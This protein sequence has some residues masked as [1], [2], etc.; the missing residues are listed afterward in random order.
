DQARARLEAALR[1]WARRDERVAA[2]ISSIEKKRSKHI[3]GVLRDIG[4][5]P[6]LAESW[7][8]IA[9][10]VYLGW[11]DRS[12]RDSEFQTTGRSLSESLSDLILAASDRSAPATR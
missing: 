7:A 3:A 10:L 8:E 5:T 2:R 9:L 11:L 1:A 12:T 4:F 6:E